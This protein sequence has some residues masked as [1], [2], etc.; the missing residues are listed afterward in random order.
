M[1]EEHE[2]L[3]DS[4]GRKEQDAGSKA[5]RGARQSK[6]TP[7]AAQLLLPRTL[8]REHMEPRTGGFEE[9]DNFGIL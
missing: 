7:A 1:L 9:G 5:K 6:P 4:A 2:G 8:G 3:R